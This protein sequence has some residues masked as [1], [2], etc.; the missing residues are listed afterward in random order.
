MKK[1]K[2]VKSLKSG[3]R[4]KPSI[5]QKLKILSQMN[6]LSIADTLEELIKKEYNLLLNN[7]YVYLNDS[8]EMNV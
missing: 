5:Y 3:T 2:E 8:K 6:N 1:V 7:N 4:F